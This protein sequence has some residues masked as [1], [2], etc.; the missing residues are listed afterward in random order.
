MKRVLWC[1]AFCLSCHVAV[2]QSTAL[3]FG[4]VTDVL[5][6]EPLPHTNIG[7]QGT[8]I[9]TITDVY[10]RYRLVL[11]AGSYML[12]FTFVGY[13]P[14]TIEVSVKE[15]DSLRLDVKLIPTTLLLGEVTVVAEA[16]AV[17][18]VH[19]LGA[20]S[21]APKQVQHLA[22][23][24]GDVS[25]IVQTMAGV[26]SNNEMSSQF[27]VRG[28]TALENLILLNGVELLEPFHLKESPNTSLSVFNTSLLKRI[29]FFSGGFPARYGDRL[30]AVLDLE[31][32]E[33]DRERLAGQVDASLTDGTLILE[34]PF[35]RMG[36]G[37]LSIRSTYSDYVANY[38]L[39]GNLRTPSFYD[40]QGVLGVDVSSGHHLALQVLHASDKTTGITNGRS[41]STLLAVQNTSFLSP[42]MLFQ[43]TISSYQQSEDLTRGASPSWTATRS[44]SHDDFKIL[45]YEMKG[46]LEA[47]V[48]DTFLLTVGMDVQQYEYELARRKSDTMGGQDSL[49]SSTLFQRS[50]KAAAYVENLIHLDKHVLIN[51]GLRVDRSALTGEVALSPR[52]LTAYRFDD[53]TTMKAAW[54]LY[55]QTPSY[56]QLFSAASAGNP[57]QHMQRAVHY[58]VGL[59]RQLRG[60]FYFKV[61]AYYKSLHDL[62][63]FER[64]RGGELIHA[65]RNDA[66][67]EIKGVDFETSFRDERLMGWISFALMEAKEINSFDKRGWRFRPTDQSRTLTAV[68]EFKVSDAWILNL[69]SFYG[70]GFAYATDL[71]ALPP[72]TKDPRQH[73]PEYKRI[74]VRINYS[75]SA[76]PFAV[77]TFAEITNLFGQKNTF[78]F[79]G[80]LHDNGIPDQNLLLPFL[81]NLG[82]R[83][84]F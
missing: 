23:G 24:L 59:E 62:I 13:K 53:E 28:G 1:I 81:L 73:Y 61:E 5:S 79:T 25:K 7:I 74:D 66:R 44:W 19:G 42:T 4:T 16:E 80:T 27:N 52:V 31:Y 43:G 49:T 82:V 38:L 72:G 69:R 70:S 20:L 36:S 18:S 2:S 68:F 32:R 56:Q 51:A 83:I 54:G 58:I 15:Q 76:Q 34:G 29:L 11:P 30:S 26:A 39:D 78:S 6:R 9:G 22:G 33:G 17:T 3:I 71:P 41:G 84:K 57:P 75:F 64:L 48:D 67:G 40:V 8:M 12:N 50:S 10:G 47:K 77:T 35:G 55:Y 21:L 14:G 65:P 63:S 37:L 60:G 46:R 45:L